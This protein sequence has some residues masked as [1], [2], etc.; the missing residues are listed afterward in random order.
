[1]DKSIHPNAENSLETSLRRKQQRIWQM[2]HDKRY[3]YSKNSGEKVSAVEK[4]AINCYRTIEHLLNLYIS[5]KISI[6]SARQD[7]KGTC[8]LNMSTQNAK[9]NGIRCLQKESQL[10][11][12]LRAIHEQEKTMKRYLEK[13]DDIIRDLNS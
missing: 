10:H 7:S 1:M 13:V 12:D 11:R 5:T 6:E 8:R 3:F 9:C 2:L 4:E